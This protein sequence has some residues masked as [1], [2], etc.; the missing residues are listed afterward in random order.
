[1]E[2]KSTD[3]R[4]DINKRGD[5]VILRPSARGFI[6]DAGMGQV[7]SKETYCIFTTFEDHR[8]ISADDEWDSSWLWHRSPK[9]GGASWC[10]C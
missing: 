5:I 10:L 4:I 8:H 1:M 7:D 6:Y 2:W 3:P 9:P